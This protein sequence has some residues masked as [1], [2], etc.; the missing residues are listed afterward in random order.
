LVSQN[1]AAASATL[2]TNQTAYLAG[3]N[4]IINGDARVQQRPA[5]SFATAAAGYGQCDRWKCGN[6]SGGGTLTLQAASGTDTNGVPKLFVQAYITAALSAP[7]GSAFYEPIQHYVEGVNCFDLLGKQVTVSFVAK[8]SV[9]GT[10]AVTLRNGGNN[11]SCVKTV[12]LSAGSISFVSLTFPALPLAMSVPNSTAAGLVLDIG[13]VSGAT[14]ATSTKDAWQTG[15]YI[16]STDAT[17]WAGT[18]GNS[19][20]VTEV[21]LEAGSVATPFERRPYGQE[22]A[23][24]E[25]YY[26]TTLLNFSLVNQTAGWGNQFTIRHRVLMRSA[27]TTALSGGTLGSNCTDS[28]SADADR[29]VYT[30]TAS[31]AGGVSVTNRA[32]A[33]SAEL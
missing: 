2:T 22:L 18:T 9:A 31:V 30:L 13:S 20:M 27:S 32:C 1:A 11:Y 26:Q 12:S 3:K 4:R 19:L 25:R 21:Q 15:N 6:S 17:H 5:T 16:T 33:L 29:L 8:A 7:T 10:Y 24:C 23:L 28:A 14:F